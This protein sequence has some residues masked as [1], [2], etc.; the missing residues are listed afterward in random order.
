[1]R[2][3]VL[4]P[5]RFPNQLSGAGL[6][7]CR[8]VGLSLTS[9]CLKCVCEECDGPAETARTGRRA[10]PGI[11]TLVNVTTYAC[12]K[13]GTHQSWKKFSGLVLK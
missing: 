3:G 4:L 7:G 12:M 5:S 10:A 8:D 9:G 11:N 13:M 6:P 2:G 1:M